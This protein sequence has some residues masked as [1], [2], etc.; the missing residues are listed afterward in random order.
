MEGT[1]FDIQRFSLHDGPGIRTIVFLKGC[2]LHCFWCQNP[3]GIHLKPE[4]MFYPDRCIGCGRCLTICPQKAHVVLDGKHAYLRQ[5]CIV[6]GRCTETCYAGALMLTGKLMT[7]DEVMEEVLKDRVF[8]EVSKGGV[9]LSGGDPSL[10]YEFSKAV[11]ERCKSEGLH[12][13][14]ET[15]ANCR[16]ESLAALLPVTDLVMM[17]IKH[18]DPEK[19]QEVTG[20]SNGVILENATRMA[21]TGKPLIIRVPVVP[22]VNDTAEEIREI[23]QFV[24]TFPNLEYLELLPFHRFG[25]SKYHALGADYP[26]SCLRIPARD[27]MTK[28]VVAVRKVGIKV[29]V[30]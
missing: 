20:V 13:A 24:R 19:H 3:E 12:T 23:A 30:G 6:C 21:K 28:L 2:S 1:V 11:L 26:A 14:I 7:V 18:L 5:K 22:K 4:I 29:R 10:Q 27:K 15:A 9:T 17:D 8:Y 16:W 25:E